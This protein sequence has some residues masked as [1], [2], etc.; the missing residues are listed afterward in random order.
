MPSTEHENYVEILNDVAMMMG[1]SASLAVLPDG[2]RPDVL[3]FN[4]ATNG[5]F[6]G[7]AKAT[8]SPNCIATR[9]R[10]QCY[11]DW[12]SA[13]RAAMNASVCG[14]CFGECGTAPG[15]KGL[16]VDTLITGGLTVARLELY[17]IDFPVGLVWAQP[18]RGRC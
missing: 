16:L 9:L 5:V 2:T 17:R 18:R 13:S 14:I 11:V 10:Y 15:W 4:F 6:L 7:D 3:R 1:F 8:E 12:L